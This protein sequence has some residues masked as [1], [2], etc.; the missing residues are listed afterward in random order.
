MKVLFVAVI[1]AMPLLSFQCRDI[2]V[3]NN[4][5]RLTSGPWKYDNT[6]LTY[7]DGTID[8]GP[9]DP[10]KQDD[11]FIFEV[12][13]DATVLYGPNNCGTAGISGKYGTW[14]LVDNDKFVKVV[15]NRD[16]FDITGGTTVTY[17]I[18]VLNDDQLVFLRTVTESG[19]T[20][21]EETSYSR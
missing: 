10:C 6:K 20:F 4:A 14:E 2:P 16:M 12:N 5:T 8:I 11:Q 9:G 7:D 13:G 18:R 15:Y 21:E 17:A 1:A 19:K 3:E